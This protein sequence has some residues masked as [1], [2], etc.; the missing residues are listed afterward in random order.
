MLVDS[1]AHWDFKEFDGERDD[2]WAR[3]EAAGVRTVLSIGTKPESWS[4][5]VE[6]VEGYD[7]MFATVGVHPCDSAT[8]SQNG[9]TETL[10]Q[11]A[12]HPKVVGLGE[13]GLDC[14][15]QPFDLKH[16]KAL[17]EA[18]MAAG[19]SLDLPLVVHTRDAEKAT[20]D[21]L[22]EGVRSYDMRGVI[23]CFSGSLDFAKACL[24]L[25]FYISFSGILT[26]KNARTLHEVARFVPLDR[27]LVETDAPYL[28]P[29]PMRG[30]RNESSFVRHTALALADLKDMAFDDVARATT[31]NFFTLF[32]KAVR[33]CV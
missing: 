15:H 2:L 29:H 21:M 1:H 24:D 6:I 28:A 20:L 30:K 12:A 5:I 27:A 19:K 16:Q 26:F 8:V 13:T 18:H 7:G 31:D 3:A 32:T 17:F 23:H 22:K 10:C 9:L 4:R 25:G 11:A 33:P 14:F